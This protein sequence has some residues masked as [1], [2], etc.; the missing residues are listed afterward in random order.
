MRIS[1]FQK[2]FVTVLMSSVLAILAMA[3]L[4]NVS[5]KDGFQQYLNQQ[6]VTKVESLATDASAYYSAT[7][8]WARLEQSPHL[9]ASLLQ[10]MGEMPPPP[11]RH[12]ARVGQVVP[13]SESILAPLSSRINLI[14]LQGSS[15]LGKP[16]NLSNIQGFESTLIPVKVDL[17][18]VGH[19]SLLQSASLTDSLAAQFLHSQSKHLVSISAA[20]VLLSL[21]FAFACTRFLVQPLR[22][23]HR[24]AKKVSLGNLEYQITVRGSDEIADVTVAFNQLVQS[25]KRQERLREQWLS[26]ISHELRTPLSV[27]RGELEALQDGIRQPTVEYIESLHQQVLTLAQLVDDLRAATKADINLELS[28]E[29]VNLSELVSIVVQS[30]E[31]RFQGKAITLHSDT[32]QPIELNADKQKVTQVLNNLLENSFRYT[33]ANGEVKV[34]LAQGKDVVWLT[35]ED[36]SPG[37][38]DDALNRLCD[39]LYRVDQS[40][41]RAHGGSGLGLSICQNI[42]KAHGGEVI[43]SHSTLGG[44]KVVLTWPIN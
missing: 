24:G 30:Y 16:E 17:E 42:V 29:P 1:L 5:F 13:R 39:R 32:T 3:I 22:A 26:D 25:L 7:Y 31:H 38:P 34:S 33:D 11:E 9:W 28:L 18:T 10:Q 6:E 14:D 35:V 4:V 2:L 43:V 36:S 41:S 15:L 37:V 40:R 12:A 44:V 27:L 21:L 19:I 20:T 23:L 8:G